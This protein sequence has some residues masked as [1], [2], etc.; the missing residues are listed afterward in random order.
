MTL[1]LSTCPN[2]VSLRHVRGLF[3]IV[4]MLVCLYGGYWAP[5]RIAEEIAS[6]QVSE[7]VEYAHR[8]EDSGQRS[9]GRRCHGRVERL[10]A[11]ALAGRGAVERF[12]TDRRAGAVAACGHEIS[13]GLCAP[14]RC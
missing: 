10:G 8:L 5:T 11:E 14:Q 1:T 4:L 9:L 12:M 6:E 3:G 13:N 7:V 2:V